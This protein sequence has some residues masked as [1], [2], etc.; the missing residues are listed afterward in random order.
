[1]KTIFLRNGLKNSVLSGAVLVS[2][3]V[4]MMLSGCASGAEPNVSASPSA[5]AQVSI[6][7]PVDWATEQPAPAS[8]EQTTMLDA[9]S[10]R[11][12]ENVDTGTFEGFTP[13]HTFN[14]V[15]QGTDM[16][17]SS[18][19]YTFAADFFSFPAKIY[20]SYAP[21]NGDLTYDVIP[22]KRTGYEE[23]L[24]ELIDKLDTS[25]GSHTEEEAS[26]GYLVYTWKGYKYPVHIQT[27]ADQSDNTGVLAMVIVE[28]PKLTP[29]GEL[30]AMF[31]DLFGIAFDAAYEQSML[32]NYINKKGGTV[33]ST[34]SYIADGAILVRFYFNIDK[35]TDSI[36]LDMGDYSFSADAA[37]AP[38][39]Y[40]D[41][42]VKS[43][44]SILGKARKCEYSYKIGNIDR[45]TESMK[46]I[47][48]DDFSL[49]AQWFGIRMMAS[50]SKG[51]RVS[52]YI[53]I[54]EG[55]F[56]KYGKKD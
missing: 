4:V 37:G 5:L 6:A 45:K 23:K 56:E 30:P 22:D 49:D 34:Q 35:E 39:E 18:A 46:G 44:E 17:L 42:C 38:A 29:L 16:K 10:A 14:D 32:D 15:A 53:L 28:N 52:V 54:S 36:N 7:P 21:S 51:E 55:F 9:I 40:M 1:M 11:I 12:K 50:Y 3:A 27:L 26:G 8:D 43:L 25:L 19:T 2:L 48:V 13:G 31:Y 20:Y 24:A 47:N 33:A 41:T